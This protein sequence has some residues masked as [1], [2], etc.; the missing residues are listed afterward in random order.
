M[1]IHGG[2]QGFRGLETLN[3]KRSLRGRTPTPNL[4]SIWVFVKRINYRLSKRT[5]SY[6]SPFGFLQ[7]LLLSLLQLDRK[8]V[9]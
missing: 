4:P 8:S 9:V 7:L 5:A 3:V 2:S 1:R 6:L